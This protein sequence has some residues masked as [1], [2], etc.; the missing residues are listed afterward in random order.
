M[1]IIN[2][3]DYSTIAYR[4]WHSQ[5][6]G[7]KLPSSDSEFDAF[8]KNLAWQA[9]VLLTRF[10][11]QVNVVALDSRSWRYEFYERSYLKQVTDSAWSV[12]GHAWAMKDGFWYHSVDL[13]GTLTDWTKLKSPDQK[14]QMEQAKDHFLYEP[15]VLD[16][17]FRNHLKVLAGAYKGKR[18]ESEWPYTTPKAKYKEWSKMLAPAFAKLIDGVYVSHPDCEADDII[19]W[20]VRNQPE[21]T[22]CRVIST[23]QD[24]AVSETKGW[25][26]LLDSSQ[27][28]N[29][30][31]TKVI[32]MVDEDLVLRNWAI[33]ILIGD[34]GDNIGPCLF[35][36][37]GR[38]TQGKAEE[39]VDSD[40][41]DINE[42]FDI[43]PETFDRNMKLIDLRNES[44]YDSEIEEE[45]G[46]AFERNMNFSSNELKVDFKTQNEANNLGKE[47]RRKDEVA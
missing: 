11:G 40:Y 22:L 23:D 31:D 27:A 33:K 16:E 32:P 18:L 1:N 45:V 12:N 10:R 30:V 20:G 14:N 3:I 2:W 4:A 38:V 26:Q 8:C 6:A 24:I 44:F 17:T 9:H 29:Q 46:K 37:G 13:R 35:R 15:G 42:E 39:M 5:R 21:D 36:T 19:A 34:P 28:I 43:D 25:G 7:A 41:E 47:L